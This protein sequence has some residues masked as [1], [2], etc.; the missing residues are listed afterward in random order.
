MA[1]HPKNTFEIL[2][3]MAKFG[4]ITFLKIRGKL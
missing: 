3:K 4:E 1:Y 2:K